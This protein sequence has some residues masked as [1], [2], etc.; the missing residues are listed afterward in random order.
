MNSL[1]LFVGVCLGAGIGAQ[2]RYGLDV[3]FARRPQ[4]QQPIATLTANIIGSGLIGVMVAVL[5]HMDL[6]GQP[7]WWSQILTAGVAGGL[8]T[9][10]T[11]TSQ[12]IMRAKDS[13]IG[14]VALGAAH[15]I[16]GFGA[17]LGAWWVTLKFL[18]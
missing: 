12:V 8:T 1:A 16:F 17:A 11:F 2:M 6:V 7:P 3:L 14:A 13:P 5:N 18:G 4:S 9:F 15:V 10:S